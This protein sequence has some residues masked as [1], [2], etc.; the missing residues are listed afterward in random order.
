MNQFNELRSYRRGTTEIGPQ[1]WRRHVA[2]WRGGGSGEEGGGRKCVPCR[3]LGKAINSSEG[4]HQPLTLAHP[5]VNLSCQFSTLIPFWTSC[6]EFS[7]LEVSAAAAFTTWSTH[8]PSPGM[9]KHQ[10]NSPQIQ[11]QRNRSLL[12]MRTFVRHRLNSAAYCWASGAVSRISP[13]SSIPAHRGTRLGLKVQPIS[14]ALKI[15]C[16]VKL[17]TVWLVKNM[18][19]TVYGSLKGFK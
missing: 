19:E 14:L 12:R 9:S 17:F 18:I 15:C 16:S 3:V 8:C 4:I 5:S 1:L 11:I 7:H 10:L 13:L 6:V 2:A